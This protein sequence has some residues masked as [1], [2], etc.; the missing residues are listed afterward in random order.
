MKTHPEPWYR[1][2]GWALIAALAAAAAAPG[3]EDAPKKGK[4]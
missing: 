2:T 1:R 3:A 4:P